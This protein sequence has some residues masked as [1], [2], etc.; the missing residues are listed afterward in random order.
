MY[1]ISIRHSTM[2]SSFHCLLIASMSLNSV[3]ISKFLFYLMLL[4]TYPFLQPYVLLFLRYL[5]VLLLL[6][7]IPYLVFPNISPSILQALNSVASAFWDPKLYSLSIL[8]L[9]E[10]IHAFSFN[11][12]W[13]NLHTNLY[14]Q[15]DFALQ[16]RSMCLPAYLHLHFD[17][18][19]LKM[20][21]TKLIIFW[22]Q[23]PL[24]WVPNN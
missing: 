1:P 24:P 19:I 6:L 5:T 10:F 21:K 12:Y 18:F 4:T 9:P 3:N 11:C 22:Y 20:A 2:V 8:S 14:P 23:L 13:W 17:V 16:S 7:H 15:A